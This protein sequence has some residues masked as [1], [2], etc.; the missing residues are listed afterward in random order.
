VN[1]SPGRRRHEEVRGE[2]A[3]LDERRPRVVELEDRL[4]VRDDDVVQARQK[5]DEEEQND[6]H[7]GRDASSVLI[8]R[9]GSDG[10]EGR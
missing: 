5:P 8:G 2:E 4:E 6:E 1:E 3:E 7:A 10:C 9:A